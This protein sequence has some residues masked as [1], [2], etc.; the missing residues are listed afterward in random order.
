MREVLCNYKDN[1]EIIGASENNLKHIDLTIPKGKLVVLAGVSGSGKSSL[2]FDTIAVESARQWQTSYPLYLRNKMPHYE[3]PKV[4]EIHNLTPAVVVDQKAIGVSSRSTVGTAVDVA[5]LIRLLFSRI[6]EPSAGGAMAY[7]FNH[8]LGMCPTCTGLGERMELVEESLFNLEGTLRKG[9]LNFSQFQ[10][11]WQN[12]LY[13]GN[14]L[15]DP[16]KKLKYYSP[17]E[18]EILRSGSKEPLTIES[19][20]N[21]IGHMWKM[22]YEGVIPRFQRLY[23]NRDISKLKKTLQEEILT[24]IRKSP[25]K[26]CGGTGLNPAALASKIKGRNIIDYFEMPVCDLL[27]V[28]AEIDNPVGVSLA[29]QIIAYLGRMVEVGIGYL[30]L[31]RRTDT[32]SGGEVQRIKMVRNLGNSLSNITY[33]FDEPTAGLHPADADRIGRLLVELRDSHN[34]VLVVEHSRQMMALADHI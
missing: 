32:L 25:C 9:G 27:P 28:L 26:T 17:E 5:P 6:G 34:N 20:S 1:I 23:L 29:K 3:R 15:L 8:P 21:N 2:A 30:S 13:T 11:T 14:P 22:P 7:S 10:S 16:D 33:I 24:H 31:S 4:D 18:W 19:P 12:E